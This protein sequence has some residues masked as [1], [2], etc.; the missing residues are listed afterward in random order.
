MQADDASEVSAITPER[1]PLATLSRN[2]AD[3][4]CPGEAGTPLSKSGG[5][6]PRALLGGESFTWRRLAAGLCDG[7][8]VRLI[9]VHS[10]PGHK[11]FHYQRVT[12][13][14]PRCDR[15]A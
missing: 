6:W 12:P 5:G 14:Y 1:Q 2:L 15:A 11:A 10:R 3:R 8:S 4:P 9:V 13:R 7:P